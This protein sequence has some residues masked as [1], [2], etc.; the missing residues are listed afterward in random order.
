MRQRARGGQGDG[1]GN[2]NPRTPCGVRPRSKIISKRAIK[3][4]STHPLRGATKSIAFAKILIPFQ[5]TH[6]LRGA[7]MQL[8]IVLPLRIISI[9]APLAGCDT[10]IKTFCN[11]MQNFNP[12]TPCGVRPAAIC[13]DIGTSGF[14]STHPSRGATVMNINVNSKTEISIHAPLAGCDTRPACPS[15]PSHYFNPRTPRGVRRTNGTPMRW[16]FTISIH[17]PLAGC[18]Q[19]GGGRCAPF[20]DFNPRT[21]R[22][23]R[24]LMWSV[25]SIWPRFQSTH[26]LRGATKYDDRRFK[27]MLISIHAPLAGC[28]LERQQLP[29]QTQNFNPRTPCGVR[30]HRRPKGRRWIRI[31]IHA[32]L[33]GCDL[34]QR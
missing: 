8:S 28:D 30:R 4:Q 5:S 6:P 10:I 18:D 31:S 1:G 2:F 34:N 14:Q 25:F 15:C 22:G 23:V 20:A 26:P 3:F 12:R 7:T 13:E 24:L 11:Q 17:A 16:L 21:P 29:D 9:H 19:H 33:A 27:R 32:P